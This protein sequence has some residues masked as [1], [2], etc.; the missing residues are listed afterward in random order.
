MRGHL[1]ICA[2]LCLLGAGVS[3]GAQ[4]YPAKAIRMVVGVAP[5][6]NVDITARLVSQKLTLALNQSVVVDNRGGAGGMIGADLVAKSIPDGYTLLVISSALMVNAATIKNSPYDPIRD[7]APVSTLAYGP[8]FVVVN[9][10]MPVNSVKELIALARAKPG[11]INFGSTG[12]GSLSHLE[13]EF[14][15]S[16]ASIDITFIPYKGNNLALTDLVS[17]N[18]QVVFSSTVSIL[19]FVRTGK[20][21]I[22]AVTGSTRLA[23]FPEIPTVAE[24]GLPQ[25]I[26][27][28]VVGMLAPAKTPRDIIDRLSAECIKFLH[29]SEVRNALEAQGSEAGGSTPQE[30]SAKIAGEIARWKTVVA[31]AGIATQ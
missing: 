23:T 31:N 22:I 19:P 7:F 14:F 17:G 11:S 26:V 18:V 5:G 10:A 29:T 12:V 21:R 3:A 8:H 20:V 15:K 1:P 30:Y 2:A 25:F 9:A 24:S 6:G 28:T 27:D 4:Q 16:A 13:G